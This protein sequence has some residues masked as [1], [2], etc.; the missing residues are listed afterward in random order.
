MRIDSSLNLQF[1]ILVILYLRK[2]YGNKIDIW[3]LGIMVIEMLD[4]EP[5]YLN[6]TPLRA[7]YLIANNG[8]PAINNKEK[9]SAELIAFLDHSLEVDQDERGSA[10][11]LLSF[12]FLKKKAKLSSLRP[13]IQAAKKSLGKD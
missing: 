1:F 11:E 13:L 3:S 4:G 2:H 8:K 10:A 12:P 5:P 7:L 9:M 6:E